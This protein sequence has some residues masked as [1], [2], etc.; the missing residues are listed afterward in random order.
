MEEFVKEFEQDP[1]TCKA[2]HCKAKTVIRENSNT[3]R[4]FIGCSNFPTCRQTSKFERWVA[5]YIG[6]DD[7][8]PYAYEPSLN[9]LMTR[10]Q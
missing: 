5:D 7:F 4:L 3:G 9:S 1:P 2:P 8:D 6:A 10:N